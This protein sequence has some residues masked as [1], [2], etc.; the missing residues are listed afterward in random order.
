MFAV[1][2]GSLTDAE[3]EGHLYDKRADVVLSG[4]RAVAAL[5]EDS[6]P[7]RSDIEVAKSFFVKVLE[8]YARK[9]TF[10]KFSCIMLT[11]FIRDPN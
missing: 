8:V 2:L 7:K 11:F 3:A 10:D 9:S 6:F 5:D 4:S 1:I